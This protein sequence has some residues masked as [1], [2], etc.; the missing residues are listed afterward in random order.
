MKWL[1]HVGLPRHCLRLGNGWYM[2]WGKK[3]NTTFMHRQVKNFLLM[4]AVM[5]SSHTVSLVHGSSFYCNMTLGHWTHSSSRPLSPAH[6][7]T[8]R[9]VCGT[10]S[11]GCVSTHWPATRSPSTVWPSARM[12]GTSP[13]APSTSV[14]TSG[15]LRSGIIPSNYNHTHTHTLMSFGHYII[16]SKGSINT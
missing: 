14:S 15:T 4:R 9:C 3:M 16:A 6:H 1:C 13:A 5:C 11:A 12:A 8:Q 2:K 10:W 7:L